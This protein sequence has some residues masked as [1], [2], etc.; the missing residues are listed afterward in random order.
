MACINQT[1]A[2][3]VSLSRHA[4]MLI[5]ML[6]HVIGHNK[7]WIAHLFLNGMSKSDKSWESFTCS[8][9]DIPINTKKNCSKNLQ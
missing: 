5:G 9:A 4:D 6:R 8:H 2:D 1:K 7:A 3:K